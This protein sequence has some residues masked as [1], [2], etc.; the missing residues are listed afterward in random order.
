VVVSAMHGVT[1]K[2]IQCAET[3]IKGDMRTCQNI[4]IELQTNHYDSISSLISDVHERD[5]LEKVI[6]SY[7]SELNT[8][9]KLKVKL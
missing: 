3:A 4:I 1:D 6:D 2:L 8:T 5:Q 7:L 9:D